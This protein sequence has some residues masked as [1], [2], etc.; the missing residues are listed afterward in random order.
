[1]KKFSSIT[2]LRID[3]TME[4]NNLYPI[5]LKL[6]QLNV[7]IVGGGKVATEKLTFL[8]KSSPNANILL[9]SK[10]FDSELLKL[11]KIH[12]IPTVKAAYNKST[13]KNKQIIIAATNS[14]NINRQIY[15]D[16]KA[17]NILINVVDKPDLCDFYS[18]SIITKGNVKIAISTDGKSPI[19]SKRLRQFFENFLPDDLEELSQNLNQY[20]QS[21]KSDFEKKV[22][23]LN[24][25][26]KK[27]IVN[28]K[29]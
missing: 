21:L 28:N 2:L 19:L 15:Q 20:R 25:L 3:L 27:L 17:E 16:A 6:S 22:S 4:Q 29:L 26:T 5:F 12:N 13:L 14:K 9:V 23:D 18:A 1:M 8:I 11:V 10:E 7:L 24:Q